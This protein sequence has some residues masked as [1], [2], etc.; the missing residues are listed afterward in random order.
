M[1]THT[2]SLSQY[3]LT[4]Q[5]K[6]REIF[7]SN[8]F[9]SYLPKREVRNLPAT[10]VTSNYCVCTGQW[11]AEGWG[12]IPVFLPP[13]ADGYSSLVLGDS[14]R[15]LVDSSANTKPQVLGLAVLPRF[16]YRK[17]EPLKDKMAE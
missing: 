16:I 4:H 15:V 12:D 9:P 17:A 10:L 14:Q 3:T 8:L 2:L 7:S 5:Q 6:N 13:P 1:L 11:V